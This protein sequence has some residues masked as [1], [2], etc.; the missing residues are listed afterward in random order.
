MKNMYLLL[1]MTLLFFSP[2]SNLQAQNQVENPEKIK[3]RAEAKE[4]FENFKIVYSED[5]F[6]QNG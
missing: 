4:L 6:K 5:S 3:D 1:S 2:A